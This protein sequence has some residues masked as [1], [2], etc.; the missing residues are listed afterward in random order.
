MENEFASPLGKIQRYL[1]RDKQQ[2]EPSQK[3]RCQNTRSSSPSKK[4]RN[5]NRD[6]KEEYQTVGAYQV[7]SDSLLVYHIVE[8]VD[9]QS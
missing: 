3:D 9:R 8:R 2:E 1:R 5:T 7:S 6:A 4:V